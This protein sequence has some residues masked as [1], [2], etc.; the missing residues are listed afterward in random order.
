MYN[1]SLISFYENSEHLQKFILM[2]L[3]FFQTFS[4][5]MLSIYEQYSKSSHSNESA[6]HLLKAFCSSSVKLLK[7]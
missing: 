5:N 3:S 1:A 4:K 6:F 7:Q 2:T